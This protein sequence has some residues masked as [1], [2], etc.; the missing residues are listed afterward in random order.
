MKNNLEKALTETLK[1]WQNQDSDF[2][3]LAVDMGN[4]EMLIE[5]LVD[6]AMRS[7][8]EPVPVQHDLDYYYEY[9]RM[10]ESY[11]E[12][13]EENERLNK[14]LINVACKL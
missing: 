9:N 6:S 1:A 5:D 10:C 3:E 13:V 14:A 7:I 2:K 12:L 4:I 8:V 11:K